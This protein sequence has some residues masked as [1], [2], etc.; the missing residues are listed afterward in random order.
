MD[1]DARFQDLEVAADG[2]ESIAMAPKDAALGHIL[3]LF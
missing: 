1:S 3:I 2:F